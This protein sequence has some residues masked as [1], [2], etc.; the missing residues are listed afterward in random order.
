MHFFG[1]FSADSESAWSSA[2]FDTHI[3]F[4]MK[5]GFFSYWRLL[6][7][8]IAGAREAARGSGGSFSV[9]VS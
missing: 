9:N 4:L 3:E 8:L 1:T 5:K 6:Y 2:F 7:T